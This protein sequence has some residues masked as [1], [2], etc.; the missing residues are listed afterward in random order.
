[1]IPI[2]NLCIYYVLMKKSPEVIFVKYDVPNKMTLVRVTN[3]V[4]K[5]LLTV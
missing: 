2:T 5:R 1:M 3:H 4:W